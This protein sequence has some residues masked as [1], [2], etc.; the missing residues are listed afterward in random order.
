MGC[1]LSS[2]SMALCETNMWRY[3]RLILLRIWS[4][5][6]SI[7]WL[8]DMGKVRSSAFRLFFEARSMIPHQSLHVTRPPGCPLFSSA[9][10]ATRCVYPDYLYTGVWYARTSKCS[11]FAGAWRLFISSSLRWWIP[12]V[13]VV[14]LMER[15]LLVRARG[16]HAPSPVTPCTLCKPELF[17]WCFGFYLCFVVY[18][19]S[20]PW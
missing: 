6:V 16:I 17:C 7:Y 1:W 10:V 5:R 4:L 18:P 11:S 3:F 15:G 20:L 13:F 14:F 19:S 2:I 12:G 8:I 9:S